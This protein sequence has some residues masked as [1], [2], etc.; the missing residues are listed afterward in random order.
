M[1][2][3]TTR[4]EK[5]FNHFGACLGAGAEFAIADGGAGSLAEGE[6]IVEIKVWNAH[7]SWVSDPFRVDQRR[8]DGK[9]RREG[10]AVHD[11]IDYPGRI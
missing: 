2:Y 1:L 11:G 7:K 8:R 10:C 3:D 9:G 6:Q 5:P 4:Y